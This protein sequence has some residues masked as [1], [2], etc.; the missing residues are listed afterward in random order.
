MGIPL[1]LFTKLELFRKNYSTLEEKIRTKFL[2][3]ALAL[4]G[5]TQPNE[6]FECLITKILDIVTLYN[7]ELPILSHGELQVY[8]RNNFKKLIFNRNYDL[9]L[10]L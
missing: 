5:D 8:L 10:K 4:S 2:I 9:V 7:I 1:Y 6:G 3:R